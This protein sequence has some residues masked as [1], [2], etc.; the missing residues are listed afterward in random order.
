RMILSYDIHPEKYERYYN[1]VLSEFVP[2]MQNMG[3]QMIFAW[4]IIYGRYPARQIDFI[5][6]D[7]QTLTGILDSETFKRAEERLKSY[8]INY[9]RKIVYFEN[10]FQF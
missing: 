1:Y 6:Y 3:L 5:C 4:Q 7:H 9:Q 8:T 2:G 10:R